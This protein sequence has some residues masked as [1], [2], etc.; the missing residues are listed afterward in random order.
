MWP[1]RKDNWQVVLFK[2]GDNSSSSLRLCISR[3]I[4]E[5]CL[6]QGLACSKSSGD[7]SAT[8]VTGNCSFLS[9][10]TLPGVCWEGE[11]LHTKAHV[12]QIWSDRQLLSALRCLQ[13]VQGRL[14]KPQGCSTPSRRGWLALCRLLP[15]SLLP[16][17]KHPTRTT[18]SSPVVPWGSQNSAQQHSWEERASLTLRT[19][20]TSGLS[21]GFSESSHQ[22]RRSWATAWIS[23]HLSVL[24]LSVL[25]PF[26]HLNC[27][28]NLASSW[29]FTKYIFKHS[30]EENSH[31]CKWQELRLLH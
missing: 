25:S 14:P 12:A 4:F 8:C 31:G 28:Q 26:N 30:L 21:P 15:A 24:M 2:N 3:E 7:G 6:I 9:T 1:R 19:Q 18:F 27:I 13:A 5:K 20:L 16:S 23:P 22:G 29:L 17:G 11:S 10:V